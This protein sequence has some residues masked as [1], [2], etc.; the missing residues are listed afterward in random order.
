MS[1]TGQ[2]AKRVAVAVV[3]LALFAAAA[4][5]AASRLD[6]IGSDE[7]SDEPIAGPSATSL[8]PHVPPFF[9]TLAKEADAY[10]NAVIGGTLVEENGCVL[11]RQGDERFVLTLWPHGWS[12]ERSADGVLSIVD[13]EG[14][15]AF[16]I[17]EEVALGG[18][19]LSGYP[20]APRE[21]FPEE[22]IG[23]PIPP[24]CQTDHYYITSGNRAPS[25]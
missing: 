13:E 25:F 7:T 18:G 21:R 19:E 1:E 9:P 22:L 15:R 8:I 2:T 3:P 4:A 17:G 24:R 16:R 5:F 12:V 23:R 11:L 14:T 6:A 20:G 10:P